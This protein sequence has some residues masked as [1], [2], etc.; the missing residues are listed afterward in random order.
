MCNKCGEKVVGEGSGC[1]AMEMGKYK[2]FLVWTCLHFLFSR[3]VYHIQCFT[4]FECNN[5]LRGKS[6]YAM[7]SNPFCEECYLVGVSFPLHGHLPCISFWFR[8]HLR[9]AL[10]VRSPFWT[11]FCEP[12]ESH[13]TRPASPV[14]SARSHWTAFHS[15]STP[16]TRWDCLERT[17]NF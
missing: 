13:T 10:S 4:C 8:T 5:E 3:V 11:E 15:R 1:T 12:P 7:E 16:P 17:T 14:S 2:C 9:S 6:F